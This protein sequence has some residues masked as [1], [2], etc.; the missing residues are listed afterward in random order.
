MNPSER[1]RA[2]LERSDTTRHSD[3]TEAHDHATEVEKTLPLLGSSDEDRVELPDADI[4]SEDDDETALYSTVKTPAQTRGAGPRKSAFP[5]LYILLGLVVAAAGVTAFLLKDRLFPSTAAAAGDPLHPFKMQVES[6]GNGQISIRWDPQTPGVAKATGGRMEILEQ[7]HQ[8]RTADL[9]AEQLATGHLYYRSSADQVEFRLEVGGSGG[10]TLRES[11][12]AISS[13]PAAP[14]PE[15]PKVEVAQ[16]PPPEPKLV[17]KVEPAPAPQQEPARP[18]RTFTPPPMPVQQKTDDGPAVLLDAS[19]V[20]PSATVMKP[21]VIVPEMKAPPPPEPKLSQGPKQVRIGGHVQEANLIKR[22][23]P[24]YPGLAKTARVQ[25]TVR[26]TAVIGKDGRVQNLQLISG[27]QMLVQAAKDA[28]RQ[29]IYK[30][31]QLN[32]EPM[33]VVTQIDVVFTLQ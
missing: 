32:G 14:A 6:A 31:M 24:V 10:S 7:G 23:A 1:I 16:K 18:V 3:E 33:E 26:F 27:P 5:L 4:D 2:A 22:V 20:L 11:V 15:Q 19:S 12:L 17:A 9:T 21:V 30:P 28:V 29:W 13:T 8:A 25:G